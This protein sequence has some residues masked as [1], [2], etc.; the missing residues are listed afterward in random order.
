MPDLT[1]V[2]N[3]TS[4]RRNLV[5]LA[6][7]VGHPLWSVTRLFASA[8]GQVGSVQ[9]DPNVTLVLPVIEVAF[10]VELLI[11]A[12]LVASLRTFA[13]SGDPSRAPSDLKLTHSGL[14]F[15]AGHS[16]QTL[17]LL[18]NALLGTVVSTV[19]FT[20][21][22]A[23]A[24]RFDRASYGTMF[25]Q[26][27]PGLYLVVSTVLIAVVQGGL[28]LALTVGRIVFVSRSVP[29]RL[30]G[31]LLTVGSAQLTLTGRASFHLAGWSLRV[32]DE[33]GSISIPGHPAVLRWLIEQLRGVS[34]RGDAGDV[35]SALRAIE[36]GTA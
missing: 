28:A 13:R 8:L 16:G 7:I 29:V 34:V 22:I 30:E 19:G 18:G 10:V 5:L 9:V 25:D 27:D 36:R 17:A 6:L 2:T 31:R 26:L 3:R 20:I 21:S 24:T 4:N 15:T 11:A 23:L 14:A 33:D 12:A 35:P 32:D 1:P